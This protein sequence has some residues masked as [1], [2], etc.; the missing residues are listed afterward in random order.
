MKRLTHLAP[1]FV[2]MVPEV[3]EPGLLYVSIPYGTVA[4][5]CCCGCQEEVVTPL[6]PTDWR[7]T[8]DGEQVSLHPSVGSWTLPCRSHYVIA[9]G[10]VKWAKAWTEKQIAAERLRD[11]A[12]KTNFYQTSRPTFATAPV[13]E[14]DKTTVVDRSSNYN[15]NGGL[16]QRTRDWIK[17]IFTGRP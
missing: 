5:L 11:K 10:E 12:A 3:L 1:S 13:F 17:K 15:N 2:E 7:M 14:P 8:Y 6:T 16:V 4:H 9:R